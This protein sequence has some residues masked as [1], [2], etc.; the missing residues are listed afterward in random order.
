MA[1][2]KDIN[3]HFDH[4]ADEWI[5]E[6]DYGRL[7]QMFITVL[8]NAIKYS[9]RE[10]NVRIEVKRETNNYYIAIE[11]EGYGIPEEKQATIYNKFF[12]ASSG[13]GTGLGLV[14]MK[15]IAKRHGITVNMYSKE[16]KGTRFVFIIPIDKNLDN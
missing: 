4:I 12:R 13:E 7:R 3:V 5:F 14:I 2:Q 8:D 11:D 6:G 9:D 16:A 15:N 1:R 10:K